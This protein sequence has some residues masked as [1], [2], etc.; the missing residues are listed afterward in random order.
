MDH[1]ADAHSVKKAE[2]RH[3]KLFFVHKSTS[4]SKKRHA[5]DIL[6]SDKAKLAKSGY[7]SSPSVMGAYQSTQNQWPAGY[8]AQ[9]QAWPQATQAQA[10]NWNPAYPQ[11][12]VL[13]LLY[14]RIRFIKRFEITLVGFR[15]L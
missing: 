7:S 11:Q 9:P 8:G 6:Q 15:L 14:G 13:A 3:A 4:E 5:D 1:F 2:D 12:Q 10:Q